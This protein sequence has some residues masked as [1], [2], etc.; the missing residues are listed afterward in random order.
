[1]HGGPSTKAI[2][3]DESDYDRIKHL[4]HTHS[5]AHS[6][7]ASCHAIGFATS[8]SYGNDDAS[9]LINVLAPHIFRAE[10]SHPTT[11]QQ[12]RVADLSETHESIKSVI[13]RLGHDAPRSAA[14]LVQSSI[15]VRAG[16]DVKPWGCNHDGYTDIEVMLP[17]RQAS[18]PLELTTIPGTVWIHMLDTATK[19]T[20][21]TELYEGLI[22][23]RASSQKDVTKSLTPDNTLDAVSKASLTMWIVWVNGERHPLVDSTRPIPWDFLKAHPRDWN[24]CIQWPGTFVK[25]IGF[26]CAIKWGTIS[27]SYTQCL[28]TD[29]ERC[30]RRSIHNQLHYRSIESVPDT[31]SMVLHSALYMFR[32]D[33]LYAP[34][35]SIERRRAME[36]M[37][38]GLRLALNIER[39]SR[40]IFPGTT[41]QVLYRLFDK[42]RAH[43][44]NCIR[45]GASLCFSRVGDN[46]CLLCATSSSLSNTGGVP[47]AFLQG[48]L[49]DFESRLKHLRPQ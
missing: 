40:A 31:S 19:D 15:A 49:D 41:E 9:F 11:V 39:T 6:V 25:I 37:V 8:K 34:F 47:K 14:S 16:Y 33:E 43:N 27:M 36:C 7:I 2:K 12:Q 4:V 10:V 48:D 21:H 26:H 13:R 35:S 17:S 28:A 20:S 23:K 44:A 42:P 5:N 38:H 30:M 18:R 29:F 1:M 24:L 32:R 45:C 22:G 3:F 46:M